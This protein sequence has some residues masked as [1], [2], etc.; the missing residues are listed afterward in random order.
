MPDAQGRLKP[1]ALTGKAGE[2]WERI[3][4]KKKTK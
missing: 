3:F 2:A 1:I 4:G